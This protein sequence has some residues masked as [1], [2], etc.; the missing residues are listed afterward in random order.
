MKQDVLVTIAGIHLSDGVPEEVEMITTGDYYWKNGKHYIL[1]D[2]I[3]EEGG[4]AVKTTVR[5]QPDSLDIMR[6]G[7][8]MDSRMVFERNKRDLSRYQTPIGELMV[9]IQTNQ[10]TM[11]EEEDLL[12]AEVEYSLEVNFEHVSDCNIAVTVQSRQ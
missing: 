8:G 12:R 4:Y 10:I 5:I 2:E 3:L 11:V 1:F 6:R 9:G 7:A